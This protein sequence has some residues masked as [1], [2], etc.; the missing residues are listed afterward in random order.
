MPEDRRLEL[1]GEDLRALIDAATERLLAHVASLPQQPSSDTDGGAELARSLREPLPET[2]RPVGELLE[3]LFSRVIPKS[4]NT[5]G[6]GYLAYIPGG[7]L[8]QAAVADLIS[9]ITNRYVGV[10]AAGPG[11][12]AIEANVLRWLCGMVGLPEGAGG[13]LT[14]GGSLSNFSALVAAR[15]DRLPE[16]FLAGIAYTSDQAHHSVQKAAMLAGFPERNVRA[17]ASD[18]SFRIRLDALAAAIREDRARGLRPFLV[19][20]N[21]GTTN[22]GAVDDL[23]GLAD[24]ARGRG[25]G[26]TSTRRTAASSS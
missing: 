17:I 9:G 16:D 13:V 5:A 11:L 14:T 24:L 2:G 26:S 25:S 8:P 4:F 12:V 20:G 7:G 3:L 23:V 10:F 19:V 6:P 22:T 15:R 18:G 1:S 21:A